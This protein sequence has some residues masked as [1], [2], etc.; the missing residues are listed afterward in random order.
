MQIFPDM[1]TVSHIYL[2][3]KWVN[4]KRASIKA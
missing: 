2:N 4:L 3:H 1:E